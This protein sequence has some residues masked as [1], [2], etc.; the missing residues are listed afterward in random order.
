MNTYHAVS[1]D[2]IVLLHTP[3]YR[4]MCSDFSRS[5][6]LSHTTKYHCVRACHVTKLSLPQRLFVLETIISYN[7][8]SCLQNITVCISHGINFGGAVLPNILRNARQTL[9]SPVTHCKT[10]PLL[11]SHLNT[12]FLKDWR[13]RDRS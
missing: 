6:L 7:Y 1:L 4:F 11:T 3:K 10:Q 12:Q 5:A 13:E 8:V 2:R 9:F